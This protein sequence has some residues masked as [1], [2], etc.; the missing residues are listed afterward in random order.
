[1]TALLHDASA[2]RSEKAGGHFDPELFVSELVYADDTLIVDVSESNV[3]SFM[4]C[5]AT[6][7]SEYG[8]QFNW[9]KLEALPLRQ[10]AAIHQPDGTP[11]AVKDRIIYLGSLLSSDRKIAGELGRRIGL[12]YADFSSLQRIWAHNSME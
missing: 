3:Q 9:S 8:L 2:L 4:E 7:G 6:V 1:M 12:A 5:I 10:Q 11:I